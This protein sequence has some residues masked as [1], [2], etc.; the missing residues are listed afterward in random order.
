MPNQTVSI[1]LH[2]AKKIISA[3]Q[4]TKTHDQPITIQAQK[5]VNYELIDDATQRAP[6]NIK[7]QRIGNDLYIGFEDGNANP[8]DPDLI[9][10]GYYGTDGITTN[11]IIG[12]HENG[13]FYAYVPESGL[14]ENAVSMLADQVSAGQALGGEP[15]TSAAYEFN[16]YWLL[17][18]IPLIGLAAAGGGGGGG[19]GGST[20]AKTAD[21]PDVVALD[22]GQ[23]TIK[24]GA[25]NVKQ[26]I[27]YTDESNNTV[28]LTVNKASDGTWSLDQTP[29]GVTINSST[30][31]VT[32]GMDAVKDGSTV[33]STGSN[34]SDNTATDSDT[35]RVDDSTPNAADRPDVVALATGAVAVKPGAD[36][37][38]Q[39]ITY[40]DESDNPVTLTATKG[41]DGTWSLD[42]TPANVSIN[43]TTGL[44]A[45][46]PNAVKD[47]SLVTSVGSDAYNNTASDSDTALTDETDIQSSDLIAP[48]LEISAT[49][50]N[51]ASGESTTITFSFSEAVTGFNT[52]DI[53]VAGGSLTGL[54]TTDNITWTATFTQ[55]GTATA[56]S[57]SVADNTYTDLAGNLGTGDA[58]DGTDGF[59]ADIIAPSLEISATD[60]NLASGESTTITFSFSEAVTGFNTSDITVAG[61]SLTG[62]TTTDNIT[63]TATFTQ[64]G[65][66]T[67][68]SISVADNT[69][70]DLAGNLG[71]GD[72]LDGT[73]GFG[74]DIIAPTL[75]ISA[76]DLNLTSGESTTITFSFSE[77]VTGFN[78]SDITVAGGSLTGL[79]TTD[80]ITWTA[81]FT[82]DG[83]ATAPS[84][85]VADN[86]Y[87]DLAGN[88]G[89]GDAL[90]GTDSFGADIIAPTLEISATDLN[91]ASGESTT[92]TFS[93]SEAVTG[94]NTSDIT[95][96]GGSLTGLTTTD[97]I[98]WTATFTQDG[99]A[100][101]P[102][103]SVADNT[104]T[105]LAGNLGTGD[106]LDGTDGFGADIIAPVVSLNDLITN[107]QTPALTG[108]VDDPTA[109]VVVTVDGNN[110]IATNNGDGT[111]TLVDNTLPSLAE[112]TYPITVTA[113]DIAGNEGTDTGSLIINLTTPILTITEAADGYV[114]ADELSD[115]IQ[116][117][118]SLPTGTEEGDTITLTITNPDLSTS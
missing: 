93:F 40:T 61:G 45:L 62:L 41:E 95:V 116:T 8:L 24:P 64:D 34:S 94:F 43:P 106:A 58:L 109:T 65:I 57:I 117:N 39:V 83:T 88:L 6:E 25:D 5:G 108:T 114:N 27:V 76:T 78:T 99:T 74:A 30:G 72:A 89:T 70:T 16:P 38:K 73:D 77:A 97:N 9:I 105:D 33:T 87:T 4:V 28:T 111:W 81:T 14:Q 75:E 11:L 3:F 21:S 110:Y 56:P 44:V 48:T 100:T 71:T 104:Y 1:K 69:Y 107:D 112:A 35:A 118:V 79:T 101:A 59:G 54:T 84:I 98:T 18:L 52:S 66:A 20:P 42:N 103:I 13:N 96:A 91:L 102:S 22:G 23:V 50:L 115:G 31:E 12:M 19:S 92:I 47:G 55:D 68:P 63:W 49:D 82:Q 36:N 17:A 29:T 53:T 32:L 90:D 37:V 51:L 7:I 86:T 10:Q 15:L 113:T 26:V 60:L 2:D 85:S 80:N 46:N 67:A